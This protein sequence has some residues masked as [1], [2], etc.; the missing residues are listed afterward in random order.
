M[1]EFVDYQDSVGRYDLIL[2]RFNRFIVF[3]SG[4]HYVNCTQK[5]QWSDKPSFWVNIIGVGDV[6]VAC[7]TEFHFL[8]DEIQHITVSNIRFKNCSNGNSKA[9]FTLNVTKVFGSDIFISFRD[10]QISGRN[11][12]GVRVNINRVVKWA[13]VRIKILDLIVSTG[14]TGVHV[15]SQQH[16]PSKKSVGFTM[17]LA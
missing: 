17:Y 14:A 12:T 6:T 2:Y 13:Q 15:V 1:N 5:Q 4:L 16:L 8:L 3:L 7:L 10:V 9:T 11:I